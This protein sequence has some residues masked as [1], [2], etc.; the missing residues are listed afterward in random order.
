MVY[1]V[2][3]YGAVGDGVADDT[4]AISAAISAAHASTGVLYLPTG[5]YRTTAELTVSPYRVSVRGDGPQCTVIRPEL[6]PGQ[7]ALRL[8][9]DGNETGD[10][11]GPYSALD[12]VGFLGVV[13]EG[14]PNCLLLEGLPPYPHAS[15]MTIR[16]VSI[17]G[18]DVQVDMKDHCYL[19][20]F[21]RVRFRMAQTFGVRMDV[22]EDSGENVSFRSCVWS[23]GPGTGLYMNGSGGAFYVSHCS[24]DYLKR[25]VW[26]RAGKLSVVSSH[27]ETGDAYGPGGEFIL[28]DRRG[29]VLQPMLS[30]TDC[31]FYDTW[32]S[33]DCAIRL[34]GEYGTNALRVTNLWVTR[35]VV[36]TPYLIRD[37]GVYP[38]SVVVDGAWYGRGDRPTPKMRRH[39]GSELTLTAT[40]RHEVV[41]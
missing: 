34:T 4:A 6:S 18:F 29:L 41:S 13:G 40:V 3:D 24:F 9:W 33:Y 30:L 38:S 2:R 16:D 5:V 22:T 15:S 23:G 20:D 8:G 35:S 26:Q 17:T 31:D 39:N 10:R 19:V 21:D 1:D 11:P 25:A 12:G 7:Y 28:M 14:Q 37:D 32:T 36:D 27:F